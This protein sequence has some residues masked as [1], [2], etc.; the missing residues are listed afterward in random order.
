MARGISGPFLM[1]LTIAIFRLPESVIKARSFPPGACHVLDGRGKLAAMFTP[2]ETHGYTR[3]VNLRAPEGCRE[4]HVSAELADCGIVRV[5]MHDTFGHVVFARDYLLP[6]A[7]PEGA[8]QLGAE[9]EP[10]AL[11][12]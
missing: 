2:A 8:S 6:G 9:H 12:K 1:D 10:Q 5:T 11:D 3:L 7:N 4:I